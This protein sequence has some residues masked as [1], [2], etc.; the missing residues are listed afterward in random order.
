MC[1][2]CGLAVDGVWMGGSR[3]GMAPLSGPFVHLRDCAHV[4]QNPAP[5][6]LPRGDGR[7]SGL[8]CTCARVRLC[9]TA[10]RK[11]GDGEASGHSKQTD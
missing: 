7:L 9:S 4:L 5:W 8:L 1:M 6:E 11:T 10:F 2:T 3:P